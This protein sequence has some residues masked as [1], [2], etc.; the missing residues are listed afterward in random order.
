MAF[1][2][3]QTTTD[4]SDTSITEREETTLDALCRL[5]DNSRGEWVRCVR[6]EADYKDLRFVFETVHDREITRA[7]T[8]HE[9]MTVVTPNSSSSVS[10]TVPKTHR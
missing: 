6:T 3:T 9:S 5:D 2:S 8:P 10:A 7:S 1:S 4:E